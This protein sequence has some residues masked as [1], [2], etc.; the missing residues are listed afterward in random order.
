L[1]KVVPNRKG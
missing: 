1:D